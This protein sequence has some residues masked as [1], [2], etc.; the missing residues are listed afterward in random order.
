MVGFQH[1]KQYEINESTY[2]YVYN[3]KKQLLQNIDKLLEL[4]NIKYYVSYGNLL[5]LVRG[6]PIYQDD[7]LDIIFDINDLNKWYKF[8]ENNNNLIKCRL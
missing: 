7:D 8:C 1:N 5:E 6:K 3:Y 2:L 4:L